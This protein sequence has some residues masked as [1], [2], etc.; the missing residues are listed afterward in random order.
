MLFFPPINVTVVFVNNFML[1]VIILDRL[2][3]SGYKVSLHMCII[4]NNN[5]NKWEF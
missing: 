2:F 5:P 4:E 3:L 1:M